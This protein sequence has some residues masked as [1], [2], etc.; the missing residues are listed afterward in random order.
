[1][2]WDKLKAHVPVDLAKKVIRTSEA[3]HNSKKKFYR[4][5]SLKIQDD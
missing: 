3:G 5:K 4:Q 1:M 2:K